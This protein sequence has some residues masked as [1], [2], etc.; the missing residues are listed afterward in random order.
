MRLDDGGRQ[1][2]DLTDECVGDGR[3][4]RKLPMTV[5]SLEQLSSSRCE[6][7]R[8]EVPPDGM[9]HFDVTALDPVARLARGR[10]STDEGAV[11]VDALDE[12]QVSLLVLRGTALQAHG[13]AGGDG[14]VG[15]H[16]V[17]SK[18]TL[19]PLRRR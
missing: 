18:H 12:E 10:V 7:R 14:W 16:G 1:V 9:D 11:G 2:W 15:I 19:S 4:E 3:L 6:R 5:E 17:F 13:H 8:Q